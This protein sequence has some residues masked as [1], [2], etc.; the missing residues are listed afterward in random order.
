M[1][2]AGKTV[3]RTIAVE[4]HYGTPSYLKFN[5]AQ[6]TELTQIGRAHPRIASF[7]QL[8]DLLSNVG[9]QRIASMDAAG[10]DMQVL[11]LT[12]P[13][14]EQLEPTEAVKLTQESNDFVAKAVEKFPDRFVA[15][16]AL[17]TPAPDR[18]ADE[19]ERTVTKF[20]FKGA[21][22]NGHIRGRYLDDKFFWPILERAE[23]LNVPLYMHPALPPEPVVNSYYSGNFPSGVSPRISTAAW[24]W[25]IET[26]IHVLRMVL[27]GAFDQY[28]KLQLIIG[29]L[30]EALPFMLMRLEQNLPVHL[31]K[32]NRP[33]GAYF[34]EN[35][36]Y[37]ISGFNYLP[38]FLSLLLQVGVDRIMFSADHPF[39]S[40]TEARAFLDRLPVSPAD[41]E[42]I[43]HTNAE[44]LLGL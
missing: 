15:L 30:G 11:S 1:A 25:H 7:A 29:H 24:G 43:A 42:R 35:M 26:G 44:H 5:E 36:H 6:I 10:I 31:T 13:G 39:S 40:M 4:E 20:G 17:P 27:G 28:P 12:G 2:P 8:A 3:T 41:R 32:L 21:L 22:I 9:E 16:A 18:A 33:F 37:S 19:L 38:D 34:R 23:S 14:T